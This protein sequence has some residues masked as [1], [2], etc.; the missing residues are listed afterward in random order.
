MDNAL[1]LLIPDP[2]HLWKHVSRIMEIL[3]IRFFT[4]FLLSWKYG[5]R[6][7]GSFGQV[8]T[9]RNIFGTRFL[10]FSSI[11][12]ILDIFLLSMFVIFTRKGRTQE[13]GRMVRFSRR[14]LSSET[15]SGPKTKQLFTLSSYYF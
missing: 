8:C 9:A 6:E 11:L 5:R 14:D 15:D 7:G 3:E 2:G 12:G 4:K 1:E 13:R 10:D